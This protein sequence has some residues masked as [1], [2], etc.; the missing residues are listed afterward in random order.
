MNETTLATTFITDCRQGDNDKCEEL[1][2]ALE[3]INLESKQVSD[4]LVAEDLVML[5]PEN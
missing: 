2:K 5:E 1:R 3:R 4:I